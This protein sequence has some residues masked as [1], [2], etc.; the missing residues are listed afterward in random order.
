MKG[1]SNYLC[2]RRLN[3]LLQRSDLT[4]VE[5]SVLVRILVWLPNTETGDV[6]EISL[7]NSRERARLVSGMFR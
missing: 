3:K 1:R 4:P 7:V 6:S 2:P 5:I